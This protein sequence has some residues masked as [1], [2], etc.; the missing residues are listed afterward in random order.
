MYP[1]SVKFVSMK[2]KDYIDRTHVFTSSQLVS[3]CDLSESSVKTTLRRAIGAGRIERVRRGVYVSKSGQFAQTSVD[4]FELVSAIDND[5]ILSFHSAL[6]AHGVAHNVSS[7]CQFRSTVVKSKFAYA[8]ISYV[9]FSPATQIPTQ[10]VRGKGGL[11]TVVTSREQTIVDCLNYPDRCGGIEEAL[12]SLS[13]FPYIDEEAL[14]GLV[15]VQS[16]SLAARTGWLLEQKASKWRVPPE[17]LDALEAMAKGG[18]FKLDKNSKE[19]RG[20]SSCWRLC[21]PESEEEIKE[22]L[23]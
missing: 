1:F 3:H 15:S 9:P 16:A 7:V 19:S 4:P 10:T 18:P 17:A 5:A 11:R 22:W 21:L 20:W 8:G 6:E 14:R 12:M 23:L 13:L 2:F